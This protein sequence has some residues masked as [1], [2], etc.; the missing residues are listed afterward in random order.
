V[1][2]LAVEKLLEI[3][4]VLRPTD[5]EIIVGPEVGEDAAV[6]DLGNGLALVAHPDPI[7][8]ALEFLGYLAIHVPANDV[9]VTGAC[10]KYFMHV[11]LIPEGTSLNVISRIANDARKALQE[12][13]GHVVGGHTEVTDAVTHPLVITTAVG[14]AD[15][16]SIVRTSGAKPGDVIIMTKS[17][18]IEGTAVLASDFED[19]LLS[20]GVPQSAIKEGKALIR[21][22]SVVK[23]A[24]ALA[25]HKLVN[26]MHDPTEGGVIGGLTEIAYASN[27]SVIVDESKIPLK[28]VTK[29]LASAAHVD[30]L[31][32]LS[33]GALLASVPEE[34]VS[35]VLRVVKGEAGVDVT[36]IGKV[37]ERSDYLLRLIRLDGSIEDFR[38]PHVTDEIMKL[39]LEMR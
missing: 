20:K 16:E 35:D 29:L 22:V 39:W 14:L 32:M 26:S 3:L 28:P 21:Q 36:V 30:P 5:P 33:S 17:A 15:K 19:M 7:S 11:I 6:I 18:G 23:E 37:V 34:K 31:R 1:V 10:P 27:T 2:K 4:D 8:G 38:A 24:L 25:K 13:G 12:I 9:A